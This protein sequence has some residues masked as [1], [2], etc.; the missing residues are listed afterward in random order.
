MDNRKIYTGHKEKIS[1]DCQIPSGVGGCCGV[2]AD[3]ILLRSDGILS[4]NHNHIGCRGQY[5][6]LVLHG[7]GLGT[8]KDRRQTEGKKIME[9]KR[10]EFIVTLQNG[11]TVK[12]VESGRTPSEAQAL[13][14]AQYSNCKNVAYRGEL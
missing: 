5:L 7:V 8:E 11:T 12:T 10:Y 2:W 13:V 4:T 9:M 1:P 14:E 6:R 3:S